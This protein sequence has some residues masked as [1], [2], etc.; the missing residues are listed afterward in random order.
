MPGSHT[1]D[2]I[3]LVG[4]IWSE[5]VVDTNSWQPAQ[6]GASALDAVPLQIISEG[7]GRNV[8]LRTPVAWTSRPFRAGCRLHT[9][10]KPGEHQYRSIFYLLVH[11][12]SRGR[13]GV[14]TAA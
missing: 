6:S 1:L 9:H 4:R 7:D 13:Q 5:P 12:C 3:R 2:F 8:P 10:P 11:K 14:A